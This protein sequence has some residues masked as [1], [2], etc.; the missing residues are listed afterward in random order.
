[1]KTWLAA[2]ALLL[3]ATG[4]TTTDHVTGR[5][6]QNLYSLDE[7]IALGREVMA[8]VKSGMKEEG[9][10][11]VKK[12]PRLEALRAMVDRLAKV[13]HLPALPYDVTLYE[14]EEPNAMALPGGQV[15]VYS[16]LWGKE[17]LVEDEDELAFVLAHELAHVTCRHSTE[18]MTRELPAELILMG[19][20]I[21]AESK[22][23]EDL[24]A[25]LGV[26]FLAYE[27]LIAT[28]YSRAD[29][30][31]ADAVGMLYMAKAGY[32]PAAAPRVWKRSH[33]KSGGEIPLLGLISTHPSDQKR[34]QDLE[35]QLPA[36]KAEFDKVQARSTPS[37]HGRTL[38][39]L[40]R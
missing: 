35:R 27:G 17:G 21:Y 31:E 25:L 37:P 28:K 32:D 2:L 33:Q 6:V 30:S 19:A 10:R 5:K 34:Y 1:M 8:D 14:Y 40:F 11:A 13:S 24:A 38:A 23:D 16:G 36:A 29:E 39:E 20:S 18:A 15:V 3:A 4:C 22:G 12:G 26:S 7:D 9:A